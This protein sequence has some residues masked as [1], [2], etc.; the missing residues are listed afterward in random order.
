MQ[1]D[2]SAAG[3]RKLPSSVARTTSV[4]IE[5]PQPPVAERAILIVEDEYWIAMDLVWQIKEDGGSV[6]GPAYCFADAMRVLDDEPSL[7]GAILD[8]DL[9]GD[10]S[11]AVADKLRESETPFVFYTG[12]TRLQL[13]QRFS[14]V[15]T[16]GKPADW[17]VIKLAL[18]TFEARPLMIT[19]AELHRHITAILPLLRNASRKLVADPASADDL[20]E[21]TLLQAMNDR[22]ARNNYPSVDGWL[23]ELLHATYSR[24]LHLTRH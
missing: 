3:A 7:A 10:F 20:V 13:P 11:F 21:A 9:E 17:T 16:I 23:L 4:S 14:G 24:G 5:D 22:D 12:H 2:R 19:G 18:D 8:I 15:P 6:S 1:N